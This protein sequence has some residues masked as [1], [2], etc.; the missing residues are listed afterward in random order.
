MFF[1]ENFPISLRNYAKFVN[2]AY[3]INHSSYPYMH[4]HDDYWEFTII[5]N[6]IVNNHYNDKDHYLKS[7]SVIVS[8]PGI[9]HSLL[10]RSSEQ[11]R[12]IN[13]AIR[14]DYFCKFISLTPA[15]FSEKIKEIKNFRLDDKIIKE[16]E[17]NLHELTLSSIIEY[18]NYNSLLFKI[19]ILIFKELYN[20]IIARNN[21]ISKSP[22]EQRIATIISEEKTVNIKVKDLCEKLFYSRTHLDRLFRNELNTSPHEYLL[23]LKLDYAKNLLHSTDL[24]LTNI[25]LSIGF[26][27][28]GQ[29]NKAFKNK[30]DVTPSKYRNFINNQDF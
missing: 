8:Y 17:L 13:V 22:L 6:G 19:F 15:N 30:F 14:E 16:I 11:I 4:S 3:H 20:Q 5:T 9:E 29:F 26:S 23:N 24:S 21:T 12:Y 10:N 28:I 25:S 7:N 1:I 2:F 18:E 27:N